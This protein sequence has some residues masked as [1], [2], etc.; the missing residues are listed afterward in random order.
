MPP[1]QLGRSSA[2]LP[3]CLQRL[4]EIE[5]G[6]HHRRFDDPFQDAVE[7]LRECHG[8]HGFVTEAAQQLENLLVDGAE[9]C[10]VKGPQT[11]FVVVRVVQLFEPVA[12]DEPV[13]NGV[14]PRFVRSLTKVISD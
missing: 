12:H 13:T 8:G 7:H 6:C 3:I 2:L 10:R 4:L 5:E 9:S 1:V 14:L 11:S